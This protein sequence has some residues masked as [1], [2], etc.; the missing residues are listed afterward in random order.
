MQVLYLRLTYSICVCTRCLAQ[1]NTTLNKRKFSVLDVTDKVGRPVIYIN[2]SRFTQE[3]VRRTFPYT[4][5]SFAS[6]H[7]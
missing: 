3:E 1:V 4:C 5:L 7:A 2:C 6:V